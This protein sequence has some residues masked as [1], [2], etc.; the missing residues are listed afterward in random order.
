MELGALV[1]HGPLTAEF[2]T[3]MGRQPCLPGVRKLVLDLS[4]EEKYSER[5]MLGRSFVTDPWHVELVA[6]NLLRHT[7]GLQ[8]LVL[9]GTDQASPIYPLP[10]AESLRIVQH[11]LKCLTHV[12]L[13]TLA[14]LTIFTFLDLCHTNLTHLTLLDCLYSRALSPWTGGRREKGFSMSLNRDQDVC[15]KLQELTILDAARLC[16]REPHPQSRDLINYICDGQGKSI[17]ERLPPREHR[18]GGNGSDDEDDDEDEIYLPS[19]KPKVRKTK[20]QRKPSTLEGKHTLRLVKVSSWM[21]LELVT[22]LFGSLSPDC[23]PTSILWDEKARGKLKDC[24]FP[25]LKRVRVR[26]DTPRPVEQ[27]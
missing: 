18:S 13:Q 14:P 1:V 20:A 17:N 16:V 2:Y 8:T 23:Y 19:M 6:W 5:S 7:S 12:T 25:L 21:T 10:V 26:A 11:G 4:V 3:R 27:P 24:P 15:L 9:A 22:Y